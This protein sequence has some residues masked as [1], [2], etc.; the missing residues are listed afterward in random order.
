MIR[1]AYSERMRDLLDQH[2][3]LTDSEQLTLDL[4]EPLG[5]GPLEP[6]R[7]RPKYDD[8]YLWARQNYWTGGLGE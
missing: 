6:E 2:E 1:T 8:L 4:L 7:E 5:R 3:P